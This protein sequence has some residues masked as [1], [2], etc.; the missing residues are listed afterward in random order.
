MNNKY[1]IKNF[2]ENIEQFDIQQ[3]LKAV[4]DDIN[5]RL[6]AARVKCKYSIFD[7]F[8]SKTDQRDA[9]YKF[10]EF[11]SRF[12]LADLMN[13]VKDVSNMAELSTA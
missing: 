1:D 5:D 6:K 3:E 7:P 4:C 8:I 13:S 11:E 9:E 2:S 12:D 10:T